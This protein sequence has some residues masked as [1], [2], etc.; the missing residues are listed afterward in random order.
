MPNVFAVTRTNSY[1]NGFDAMTDKADVRAFI[2]WW[3]ERSFFPVA[4]MRASR[5]TKAG[6]TMVA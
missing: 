4:G 6:P 3:N 5:T 2:N 1:G